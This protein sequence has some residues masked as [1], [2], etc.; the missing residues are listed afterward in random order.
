MCQKK[1]Y[2]ISNGE[3]KMKDRTLIYILILALAVGLPSMYFVGASARQQN[4]QTITISGS[5]TV[6]PIAEAW[7]EKLE[8]YHSNLDVQVSGGGSGVGVSSVG[9]G[10]VTLGMASRAVKSSELLTYPSLINHTVAYD[11]MAMVVNPNLA[12]KITNLTILQIQQI[13]NG[14]ITNWNQ[15]NSSLPSTPIVKAGRATTSGTYDYFFSEIM[16]EDPNYA[17]DATFE[18]NAGVQGY[19]QSTPNSIGYVGLGYITGTEVLLINEGGLWYPSVDAVKNGSYPISRPLFL[20]T[21]GP[22]AA[23]SLAEMYINFALSPVGQA[24]VLAEDYV[25][26]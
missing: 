4:T 19:V 14:T 13:F 8:Q 9:Q 2:E 17:V 25:P 26:L 22:P 18:A 7:G 23:G 21:N 20:V 5:T 16:D 12:G 1:N 24:I 10:L 3:I 15:I 6:F 11:G